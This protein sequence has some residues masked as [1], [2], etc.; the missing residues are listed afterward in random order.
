[1]TQDMKKDM[2]LHTIAKLVVPLKRTVSPLEADS[3]SAP[4]GL[5]NSLKKVS[6]LHRPTKLTSPTYEV[7]FPGTC[8][9]LSR[10]TL[11][12]FLLLTLG[13]NVAWADDDL[14]GFY[15]IANYTRDNDKEKGYVEDDPAGNYYLCPAAAYYNNNPEMP[16]LTTKRTNRGA[17][18]IW[19]LRKVSGTTYYYIIHYEEGGNG[20]YLVHNTGP[21]SSKENR[22]RV[23]L[24]AN[25]TLE[26]NNNV[27]FTITKISGTFKIRPNADGSDRSLNPAT[28]NK[29]SYAPFDNEVISGSATGGIIGLW[30]YS[31][32]ASEAASRWYL[33]KAAPIIRYNSESTIKITYPDPDASIYYSFGEDSTPS[34]SMEGTFSYTGPFDLPSG[35]TT[36]KAIAVNGDKQSG[37]ATYTLPFLLGS[38][39]KYIIQSKDCQF[40]RLIPNVSVDVNTKYV[41]S[42][43]VPSTT[44]A[45]H[46]EYAED[47][48]YYIVDENGWY[49]YYTTNDNKYIYL[50]SSKD[51]NDEGFKFNIESHAT[52][53]YNIMP[54][55]K[56]KSIF[57]NN[58]GSDDAGLIPAMY[59]GK[60]TEEVARW[61]LIPYSTTNLP[62]WE[63][64]PFTVSTDAVTNYYTITPLTYNSDSDWRPLILNNDGLIKSEA[65]PLSNYDSRKSLWV[66][67]K[68]GAYH[69]T[70]NPNG[71]NDDLLDFY[72]FQNAY[73]GKLLY[74]NGAGKEVKTDESPGV[75]QMGMP[76]VTGADVTWS[77]FVIVQTRD[78]G[79]N[80]I[81]R[82]LVDNT[83]A[84]SRGS[85]HEAFNCINRANGGNFTGTWYDNDGGS[86]WTFDLKENVKCMEPVFT[87]EA[88]GDITI[89]TVT[90]AARILCT[91]D[92]VNNPTASSNEYTTKSNTS[93]QKVIKAIAI[94]GSDASTASEVVTL[95]NKPDITLEAG[96]YTYKGTAWEPEIT[97]VS[98]GETE[99]PTT[100][101]ATYSVTSSSYSNNIN[102]G[103]NTALVTLTDADASDLWYIWNASQTFTINPALVTVTA[104]D[105]TKEYGTDDPAWTATVTGMQNGES[106]TDLIHYTIS[107]TESG[108]DVGGTYAI[109]P[110]GDAAQGNYSVSYVAGTLTIEPK[111]VTVTADN[112][113]KTYGE[114][115]PALS[116]TIAGL[117]NGDTESV[118][119]FTIS[120]AE[121]E[122]AGDYIITP[123][124]EDSQ[125]NYTVTYPTGTLTINKADLTATADNMSV[126]YGDATPTYTI[127][128]AG[129]V[130]GE[131]ASVITTPPTIT[132]DYSPTSNVGEYTISVS[133]NGEATN[134]NIIAGTPGTL[135][136]GQ[137]EVGIG[138][139]SN[140]TVTYNGSAQTP[141][142]TVDTDD[143]VND[144]VI[145]VEV[146]VE[147]I[148]VN[149]GSYTATATGLTGEKAGN[150]KLP[151]T[152]PTSSFTISPAVLYAINLS[153][154]SFT[155]DGTEKTVTI[156][157]VTAG[158]GG[159]LTVS[160]TD[161]SID[162]SSTLSATN[163]GTYPVRVTANSTNYSDPVD[164]VEATFTIGKKIIGDGTDPATANGITIDITWNDNESEPP[165]IVE[166]KDGGTLLKEESE[167]S[168]YAYSLSATG[169]HD[170][171]YY[172]VKVTGANNYDGTFTAKYAN[173][174]FDSDGSPGAMWYGT[175]VAEADHAKPAGM[176]P[177]I[178][179]SVADNTATAVELDY[180]PNGVPVVLMNAE[181]AKGFLVQSGTGEISTTGNLLAVQATDEEK[182][183]ATVYLLYK[184]EFVLNKAGTLEAGTV[185]LPVSSGSGARLK[186]SRG[187][188][189]GIENI[190]YTIESQSDAWYTLDGRR[191]SCK[192]TKKGLYL[193]GG[194]KIVVK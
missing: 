9:Y 7:N 103:E 157:S 125:G 168:G 147:N 107:R 74:Y 116:V 1:M 192:P 50:K 82:V 87:E 151:D 155:Y 109:T 25:P 67:K 97:K 142:A 18:S 117:V 159:A 79:Y 182:A 16:Y 22:F 70:D 14:S 189:T 131:D 61:D 68:V 51:N 24:E 174:R 32:N 106:A 99:A 158:E 27:L 137:K 141:T 5:E 72:T 164:P 58:I 62:M 156:A 145:G 47:F 48:Y 193:Q 161:Y 20:K 37:I 11:L 181:D 178:I 138:E 118:I 35:T 152:P 194:K 175:F 169:D 119:S 77:H 140:T 65:I 113:T 166:V 84:I 46:F 75:L 69:A 10:I 83:K 43:N 4:G 112:K 111:A 17:N 171:K 154:T 78:N 90:N 104:D 130:N 121:G 3:H 160:S 44:M 184:G 180:I 139:W 114:T 191:L 40:Y 6:L 165:Y 190:E 26:N 133:G 144:D 53:G 89:T 2:I 81:P 102:A 31:T 172:T 136:V 143:L 177:Y 101:V 123:T 176:T 179:T 38:T 57:K 93:A 95:L 94:M 63:D 167:G 23:H 60:I 96:P 124:G 115:D 129:F 183:T 8:T 135:T 153:S 163:V 76:D 30:K 55:G 56:G 100:P 39:H 122:A 127:S 105:T 42:L 162:P 73:T 45:W 21:F 108:E 185:Y 91:I 188:N 126:T 59:D 186:I 149:A 170:T 146:T 28:G 173:V 92:D 132:C 13:I 85:T 128:Y 15:Y 71:D 148:G 41:S 134:Y 110:T 88:N 29:D 66:I 187:D 19:E 86:R 120:R 12:L 49:M 98:I 80:I 64:A 33:E 34:P 54:K 36:I 52:G 150:Y